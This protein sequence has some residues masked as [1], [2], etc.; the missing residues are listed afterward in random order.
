MDR[1]RRIILLGSLAALSALA[2]VLIPVVLRFEPVDA[3]VVRGEAHAAIFMGEPIDF[4]Y[5]VREVRYDARDATVPDSMYLTWTEGPGSTI[6]IYCNHWLPRWWRWDD[7]VQDVA[8]RYNAFIGLSLVFVLLLIREA[9]AK[10]TAREG[11]AI[12]RRERH[13]QLN[14]S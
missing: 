1:R 2:S 3:T 4:R 9:T 6:A 12:V 5:T 13:R 7:S 10:G 8:H 14:T 11:T